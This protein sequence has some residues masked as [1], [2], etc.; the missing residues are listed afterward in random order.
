[1]FKSS[2]LDKYWLNEDM[3][4]LIIQLNSMETEIGQSMLLTFEDV[5]DTQY[6]DVNVWCYAHLVVQARNDNDD[7]DVYILCLHPSTALTDCLN[8]DSSCVR[9]HQVST[10]ELGK[11]DS[12]R[13][14]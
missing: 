8:T 13:F 6:D 1:M 3:T 2:R 5:V 14:A 11:I 12:N 7:V 10:V 4:C 9:R